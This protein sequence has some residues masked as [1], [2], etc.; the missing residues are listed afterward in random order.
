VLR[1]GVALLCLTLALGCGREEVEAAPAAPPAAQAPVDAEGHLD[2]A[3]YRAKIE[4]LEALLYA[5]EPLDDEGWKSLS[6]ALLELHNEI[7]FRDS[8]A[9]ARDTSGRLFFLSARADAATTGRHGER[10]LEDLRALWERLRA[11][12]FAPADWIH[13]GAAER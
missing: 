11:E 13:A 5:S 4:A 2:P 3:P 8:S 10:E 6:K 7:V 1:A 9:S 12:K